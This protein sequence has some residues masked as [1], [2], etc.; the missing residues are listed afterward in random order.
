MS[1]SSKLGHLGRRQERVVGEGRG[2]RVA[3]GVVDDLL[4]E[5]LRR[6]LGDAAVP[7]ALGQQRVD[8]GAGVVDR[9]HPAQHHLAGLG[10]HLDD[11][12]VRAERERRAGRDEHG[13]HDEPLLLGQL[14]QRH[15]RLRVTG[16]RE[17]AAP[18]VEDQ[19]GRAG[20]QLG[21]AARCRATSTSS[22]DACR[23]AAP[24]CCRLREPPVPPP[25]G[26]RSVSPHFTVILSTGMPSSSLASMAHTVAWP[27]PCGEVPVRIVA[28]AVGVDLD[29]GVL[30]RPA[31]LHRPRR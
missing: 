9:H 27:C 10:V 2:Q 22:R 20:L 4:Q 11:G 15:R 1:A 14:G 16:H 3:V 29:R 17:R 26:I 5:R 7:L 25:S 30:A 23:T 28:R 21:S 12:H 18:S 24:P 19:V 6:A 8:H 13:A 31:R